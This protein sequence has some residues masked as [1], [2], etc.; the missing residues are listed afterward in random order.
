MPLHVVLYEPEIPWNTGNIGRTCV[1]AGCVLHLVGRLGFDVSEK[2]IRR[3]GLDYWPKLELRRH[4]DFAAFQ[5]QRPPRS[6]L[7][8]FSSGGQ[9][10]FWEAPYAPDCY[11]L[12]GRESTGL[13]EDVLSACGPCVYRIP[14]RPEVRSL[15]LS[16]AAAVV[17]Y[18]AVRRLGAMIP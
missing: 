17:V 3:S 15:N 14:M 12:F 2:E 11:L 1:A 6:T 13:P 16:T 10:S 7:L 18:E 5:A 8:A 9:R 4:D